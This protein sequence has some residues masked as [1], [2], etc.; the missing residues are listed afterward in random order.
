MR[1]LYV[2]VCDGKRKQPHPPVELGEF[3]DCRADPIDRSGFETAIE[4]QIA[5]RQ[6]LGLSVAPRPAPRVQGP[7]LRW[8]PAGPRNADRKDDPLRIDSRAESKAGYTFRFECTHPGCGRKQLVTER[9]VGLVI[10]A[11]G[12]G[13]PL[14][15]AG[16]RV[17]SMR[18]FDDVGNE[19]AAAARRVDPPPVG[20]TA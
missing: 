17:L 9:T 18:D 20:P 14:D 13:A 8:R 3:E 6:A 2:Q 16:R 5:Q 7:V 12:A 15:D 10:D 1:Q 11:R 19:I 4:E